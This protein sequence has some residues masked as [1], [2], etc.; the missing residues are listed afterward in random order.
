MRRIYMSFMQREAWYCQFLEEDLKTPLPRKL[1]LLNHDK[2][3]EIAERARALPN[4][5]ARQA[6]HSAIRN[7]RGGLWL[8]LTDEQYRKLK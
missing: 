2:T 8:S 7:G 3:F 6:I 1:A 4:L 5:E